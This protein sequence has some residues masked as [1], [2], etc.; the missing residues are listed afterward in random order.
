MILC[1]A[2]LVLNK[3]DRYVTYCMRPL[4]HSGE[5][6]IVPDRPAQQDTMT[7]E[8]ID[9]EL[10]DSRNTRIIGEWI[11]EVLEKSSGR[12]TSTDTKA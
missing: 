6:S 1:Q 7:K 3:D 11:K 9:K 8:Q 2:K 5:H 10:E 4:G 12:E